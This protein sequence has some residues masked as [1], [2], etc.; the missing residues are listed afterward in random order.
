MWTTE[1]IFIS[2]VGEEAV[3]D[4]IP[5]FEAEKITCNE[6]L[7]TRHASEQK[8]VGKG[9]DKDR[10]SSM[11]RKIYPEVGSELKTSSV[12]LKSMRSLSRTGSMS[13][14]MRENKIEEAKPARGKIVL[15]ITTTPEGFNSGK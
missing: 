12:N 11:S 15:Q 3:I 2:K 8:A 5:L 6:E 13:M 4:S 9:F 7:D 10:S 1:H 14:L